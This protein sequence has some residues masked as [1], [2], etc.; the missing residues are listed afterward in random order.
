MATVLQVSTTTRYHA[1]FGGA[2]LHAGIQGTDRCLDAAAIQPGCEIRSDPIIECLKFQSYWLKIQ[3]A[4]TETRLPCVIAVPAVRTD[5]DQIAPFDKATMRFFM[6]DVGK[7]KDRRIHFAAIA[8]WN[9]PFICRCPST[10]LQRG[11][12]SIFIEKVTCPDCL[13]L[14]NRWL[15]T[16]RN[17]SI[18]D[19]ATRRWDA[20]LPAVSAAQ[21]LAAHAN[22]VLFNACKRALA[23]RSPDHSWWYLSQINTTPTE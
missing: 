17:R 11:D 1:G 16:E 15:A 12:V 14:I 9:Q 20:T 8:A 3:S 10:K 22:G 5:D 7:T 18:L 2:A 21:R 6:R 13:N 19:D 23:A 4:E